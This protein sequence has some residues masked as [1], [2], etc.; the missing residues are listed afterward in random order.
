[1]AE[2]TESEVLDRVR[3]VLADHRAKG[4]AVPI[5]QALL[6]LDRDEVEGLEFYP[7][8]VPLGWKGQVRI[9]DLVDAPDDVFVARCYRLLLLREPTPAEA[10]RA[11]AS[12][13]RGWAKALL[14]SQ[15]RWSVEGRKCDVPLVGAR[16][17]LAP[18]LATSV[19]QRLVRFFRAQS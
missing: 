18:A 19:A 7:W 3:S 5:P 4:V 14:V 16:R 2:I 10:E 11:A 17:R 13:S 9:E 15:I 6:P 8:R 1:M 12:L